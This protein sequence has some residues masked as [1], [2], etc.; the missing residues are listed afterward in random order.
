VRAWVTTRGATGPAGGTPC[1]ADTYIEREYPN[2]SYGSRLKI[3]ADADGEAWAF[4]RC[5]VPDGAKVKRARLRL[6]VTESSPSGGRFYQIGPDWSEDMTWRTRP[7]HRGK[8]IAQL[9]RVKRGQ[10]V[11]V[12]VTK[13][14]LNDGTVSLTIRTPLVDGVEYATRET[15]SEHA[16]LLIVER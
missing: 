4:I 16:P 15:G 10:F 1:A 5:Q 11:E 13:A 9:G 8:L 6:Y 14:V 2:Q 3:E 7:T 12:D